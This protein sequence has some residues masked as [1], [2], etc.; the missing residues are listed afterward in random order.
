MKNHHSYTVSDRTIKHLNQSQARR[1][2]ILR[3]KSKIN[4]VV[5]SMIDLTKDLARV[6]HEFVG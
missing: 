4:R 1:Q 2:K 5:E 3:V 6:L